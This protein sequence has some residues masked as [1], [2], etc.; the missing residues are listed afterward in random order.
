[1]SSSSS[2]SNNNGLEQKEITTLYRQVMKEVLEAAQKG[3]EDMGF[4]DIFIKDRLG[5]LKEVKLFLKIKKNL[6]KFKNK[7]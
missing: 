4:D 2:S 6:K 7:K 3:L 1:M 5:R